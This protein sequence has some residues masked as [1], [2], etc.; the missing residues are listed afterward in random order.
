VRVPSAA[1]KKWLSKVPWG[2]FIVLTVY[3]AG[4]ALYVWTNYYDSSEYKGAQVWLEAR[5][6][7]GRD[8]C[9]SC[10][11]RELNLAFDLLLDTARHLPDSPTPVE[12]LES[13]RYR[14]EERHFKL[15]KERVTSAEMMSARKHALDLEKKAWLVVGTQHK[16]WTPE[17]ILGG[18]RR[19]VLWSIPGAVLIIIFWGYT[20]FSRKRA[21]ANK[22]EAQLKDS[23]REVEELGEFRRGLPP[24]PPSSIPPSKPPPPRTTR[25]GIT[26]TG[27]AV[28]RKP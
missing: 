2:L 15:T 7:L 22:H 26:T 25:T 16:G 24:A 19:T 12:E 1:P 28:K 23:E 4:V 8:G 17:K 14:F 3:A 9:R 20:L 13:L 27:R 21:L 11:E 5:E 6:L 18:P 10:S